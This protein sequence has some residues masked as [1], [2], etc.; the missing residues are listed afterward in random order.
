MVPVAGS[1]ATGPQIRARLSPL[2]FEHINCPGSHPF[3]RP[4]QHGRLREVAA[5]DAEPGR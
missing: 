3:H 5:L 2:L 4:D 1:P